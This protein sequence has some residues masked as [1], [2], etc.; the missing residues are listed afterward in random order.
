MFT[1]W[2]GYQLIDAVQSMC[3]PSLVNIC[4]CLFKIKKDWAPLLKYVSIDIIYFTSQVM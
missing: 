1:L 4:V 2:V 3:L